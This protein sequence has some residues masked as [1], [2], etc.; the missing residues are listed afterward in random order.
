[1]N[2][3][4]AREQYAKLK[5]IDAYAKKLGFKIFRI[6]C[7]FEIGG[8]VQ[9]LIDNTL[10]ESTQSYIEFLKYFREA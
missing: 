6:D 4:Q 8:K 5:Q 10:N 2:E 3:I 7:E 9:T 1:M